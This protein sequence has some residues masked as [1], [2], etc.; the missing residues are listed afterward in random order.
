MNLSSSNTFQDFQSAVV[1]GVDGLHRS[2]LAIFAVALKAGA[3]ILVVGAGGGRE[4]ETFGTSSG[5]Y[6]LVG[7]DPSPEMLALARDAVERRGMEQRASLYQ[8]VVDDLPDKPL[9][10]A[11]TSFFVMH[12]LENDG[13]KQRYLSAIRRRLRA[14]APYVHVDACF[15]GSD[16]F[17]RLEPV[18]A[19]HAMLNGL[20]P[21]QAVLLSKRVGA[22]PILSEEA[23][24]RLFKEAGFRVIAPFFKGLWYTGWWLEAE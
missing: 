3:S 4:L 9:Y 21:E 18:Y 1:P 8:G 2:T 5:N 14:G 7:V 22:M 6:L 15:D 11:A 23:L 13:S 24:C 10:D 19:A 16:A 17:G 20:E 12:F